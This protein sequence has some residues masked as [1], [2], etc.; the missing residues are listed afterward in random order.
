M[1]KYEVVANGTNIKILV[2]FRMKSVATA[3]IIALALILG[4]ML[5]VR[6]IRAIRR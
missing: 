1:S 6:R 2:M 5:G 3:V 4:L